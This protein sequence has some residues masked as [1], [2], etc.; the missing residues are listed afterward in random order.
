MEGMYFIMKKVLCISNY[1][2]PYISGV[3]E[4]ERLLSEE[5]VRRNYEVMVLTSNHDKLICK[6]I[7]N[8]VKILRAPII[9]KI[10][11]GTVSLSFIKYAC[12]LA[13]EYDYV[14]LNLPMIE[15]GVISS[16]ISRKKI[17]STFHCDI[18][19]NRGMLNKIIVK[20]MDISINICLKRSEKII[21]TSLDYVRH[22]RF[23]KKYIQKIVEAGAPIKNLEQKSEY[24]KDNTKRIGFCGRIV[25]EKGIEVLLRAFK[26]ILEK[27][28]ET[29]LLI[30][31][32]YKNIAGGSIYPRL[33]EY[34]KKQKI[35]NVKFLGKIKEEEMTNFYAS[36]DIFV[37]PSINSLEAFGLVQIEAMM[38]GV[39]VVSSDLYGVRTIVQNTGMGEL[40][41]KGDY[42]DLA[43]SITKVMNNSHIYIKSKEE[44][45]KFYS[46]KKTVDIYEDC[47]K[48]IKTNE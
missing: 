5:L 45:Q 2:Y 25:E 43:N 37:L 27:Y 44:I 31:G 7:I 41:R 12:Q 19:L 1:Y 22:T 33:L 8:G 36:L 28:P 30:A 11:K 48:K 24:V 39:P 3:T 13:K 14:I 38:S 21:V 9:C 6:D 16:L 23:A 17:I 46:T 42:K 34:I 29:E 15:S 20:I 18:N 26:I 32:D 4:Y 47:F 40:S 10:S 35:K